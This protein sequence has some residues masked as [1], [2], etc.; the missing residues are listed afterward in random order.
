[1]GMESGFGIETLS[2]EQ[3]RITRDFFHLGLAIA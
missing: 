2:C 1:M 3:L